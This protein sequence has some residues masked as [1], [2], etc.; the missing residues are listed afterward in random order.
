M[1]PRGFTLLELL[2]GVGLFAVATLAVSSTYGSASRVANDAQLNLRANGENRRSLE[3]VAHV[4]RAADADSFAGFDAKGEATALDFACVEGAD[5]SARTLSDPQTL[6]WTPTGTLPGGIA[7]GDVVWL[8]S[9][10]QRIL[11]RHV[12]DG[13]F[14]VSRAGSTLVVQITTSFPAGAERVE[15]RGRTAITIR[16]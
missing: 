2:V 6:H 16:N 9:G 1:R 13:G 12:P 4:L 5:L 7:V 10:A 8:A 11:A 15:V 14:L 3:A